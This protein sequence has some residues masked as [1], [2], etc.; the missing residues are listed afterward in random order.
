MPTPTADAPTPRPTP[1]S[2]NDDAHGGSTTPPGD[3]SADATTRPARPR[4]T[5]PSHP[6]QSRPTPDKP[7]KPDRTEKIV[8]EDMVK[9]ALQAW[10]RGDSKT[11]LALCKRV[12]Q[13]NPS[14]GPAW[15]LLGLIYERAGDKANARNAFQK[16]LQSSPGAPDA[17]GIRMRLESL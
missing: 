11:A 4:H 12:T 1:E 17:N 9:E 15:R 6:A 16:Y 10:V 13:A 3:P 14:H 5:P 7:D 8:P 2:H